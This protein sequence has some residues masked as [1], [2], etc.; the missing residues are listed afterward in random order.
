[1]YFL[2]IWGTIVFIFL[3]MTLSFTSATSGLMGKLIGFII[4]G[5][6]IWIWFGTGYRVEN[7]TVIVK[8][9]PFKRKINIQE[10]NKIG[11]NKSIWSAPALAVDRLAIQY[12]RYD[13]ILIAPKNKAEFILLLVDKNPN[14]KVDKN[15]P[16]TAS[17]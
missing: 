2:V 11:R 6:L 8:C 17:S 5:L 7:E 10:I 12:G 4:I 15:L 1:M 13:G 14:I 16:T 9:G 3:S